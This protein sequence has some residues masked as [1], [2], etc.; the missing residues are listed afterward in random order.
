MSPVTQTPG[1]RP[2]VDRP[3]VD[4]DSGAE[5]ASVGSS[6]ISRRSLTDLPISRRPGDAWRRA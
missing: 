3:S 4:S 5:P 1:E 2:S 6:R